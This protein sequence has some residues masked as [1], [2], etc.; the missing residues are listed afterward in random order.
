M[1]WI[2]NN[3]NLSIAIVFTTIGI[4]G[5]VFQNNGDG[6]GGE[7]GGE[8]GA[9]GGDH[10]SRQ[11]G[12]G[13]TGF[14]SDSVRN[15][16]SAPYIQVCFY[17]NGDT[18]SVSYFDS[19]GKRTKYIEKDIDGDTS[20]LYETRYTDSGQIDEKTN[21]FQNGN[22]DSRTRNLN[23]RFDGEQVLYYE[24]GN[25]KLKRNYSKG[26]ETGASYYNKSGKLIKTEN[27]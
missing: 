6:A 25:I 11:D 16:V 1:R 5:L 10:E 3:P 17:D 13:I 4:F 14:R 15:Q 7:I 20:R 23:D 18:S 24:N 22:I 21:Y 9:E 26:K 27:N 8:E 2:L 12:S 19:I